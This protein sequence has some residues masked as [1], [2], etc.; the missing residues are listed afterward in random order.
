MGKKE[1]KQ[2]FPLVLTDDYRS[3]CRTLGAYLRQESTSGTIRAAIDDCLG[4][5]VPE[6]VQVDVGIQNIVKRQI[7]SRPQIR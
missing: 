2:P 7:N 4:R 5:Y 6:N 3:K 1:K